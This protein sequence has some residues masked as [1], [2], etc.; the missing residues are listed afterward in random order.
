M[1]YYISQGNGQK[2]GPFKKDK[3]LSNGLK[4]NTLVWREGMSQWMAAN[5]IPELAD[6]LNSTIIP[7]LPC[8]PEP[9]SPL[10][11]EIERSKRE[12]EELRKQVNK[13]DPKNLESYIQ[14]PV[15]FKDK[16]P[17]DFPCPTWTK[18]AWIVLACVAGHFFLGITGIT[19]FFYIFFDI[20]GFVLCFTALYIGSKIKTLNKASYAERTPTREKGDKLAR[21][22]GW[23]VS[24]TT[25]IG[26]IVI[27]VHT[28]LDMFGEGMETGITYSV[29][30]IGL[31]GLLW[32]TNFRP[33]KLDNYPMKSSPT[34]S[35]NAKQKK[36][37]N[38]DELRWRRDLRKHGLRPHVDG[39][40]GNDSDDSYDSDLDSDN[41]W[42]WDSDDGY[43]SNDD[44][45]WGGGDSGGG[46][47]SS[48]W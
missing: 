37:Q 7:P 17:Y 23:L 36:L 3:L 4:S 1:D 42:D 10:L 45:D 26:M 48:S 44:Y 21:I 41:D 47:A 24:I 32:Y 19:K 28:G 9:S 38:A 46:G 5:A 18:E 39:D 8:S 34:L 31:M 40:D 29:I 33:I 13:L 2:Q 22:N 16:T 11:Q 15:K 30:Y 6:L 25:L 43:D 14:A 27:L 12:I 20:I 35:T